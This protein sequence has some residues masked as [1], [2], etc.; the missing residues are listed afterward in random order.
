MTST[1]PGDPTSADTEI[2]PLSSQLAADRLE[3]QVKRAIDQGAKLVAGGKRDGNFFE[4]G[5]LTEIAP[6]NEAYREELSVRS[7]RCIAS[8]PRKRLSSWPTPR[9]SG[10]AHTS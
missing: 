5:V 4:P 3:E 7:R 1:K 6:D 10:W 2:G 8:R 9:H